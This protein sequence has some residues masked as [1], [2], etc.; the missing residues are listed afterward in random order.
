MVNYFERHSEYH[1]D[2][3][4]CMVSEIDRSH[5]MSG[6]LTP[7]QRAL[8]RTS[9]QNVVPISDTF[10]RLF[11]GRL[12]ELAPEVKPLFK[13]SVEK[14]GPKLVAS[15]VVVLKGL[16]RIDA[17]VPLLQDLAYRH[18]AYGVRREHY[19]ILGETLLWT[20][21]CVLGKALTPEA[22]EA[23]ATAYQLLAT[24][25]IDA[26]YAPQERLPSLEERTGSPD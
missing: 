15:L 14:Q 25:C 8:V 17:L 20:L 6:Q 18:I 10:T 11:Y 1:L 22:K 13:N 19:Q 23:W 2:W 5:L 9:F 4:A 21:D 12:F 16:D 3:N 24:A 26:A 7:R